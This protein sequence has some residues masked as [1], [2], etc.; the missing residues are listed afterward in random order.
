VIRVQRKRSGFT[1]IELLVVI[2]IIAILAAILFPVF[3]R[4]RE[5]ARSASCQSNLRQLGTAI[6]IYLSDNDSKMPLMMY[7]SPSTGLYYRWIHVIYPNVN[8]RQIF[9]CPSNDVRYEVGDMPS[10]YPTPRLS[11]LELLETSYFYC[12]CLPMNQSIYAGLREGEDETAMKDI[13]NTVMLMDGWFFPGEGNG[14][15]M[16]MYWAP[17]AGKVELAKWV[18]GELPTTYIPANATGVAIMERLHRHND[19]MN[20]CYA[21]GHVKAITSATPA[22]FTVVAD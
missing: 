1:L 8:N 9:A 14:W 13:S 16:L 5:K 19:I 11:N 18:N 12:F 6:K 15:N 7:R 17:Q 4:T 3:A 2:T 21:D 20:A 10:Q 22:N